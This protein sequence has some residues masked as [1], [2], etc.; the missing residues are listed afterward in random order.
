M[1]ALVGTED[2]VQLGVIP[3]VL[4]PSRYFLGVGGDVPL[5]LRGACV[6][7]VRRGVVGSAFP[8]FLIRVISC[9]FVGADGEGADGVPGVLEIL[10]P[11]LGDEGDGGAQ[12]DGEPS[13]RREFFRDAEGDAGLA[14][15][16]WQDDFAAGL[17]WWQTAASGVLVFSEDADAFRYGFP[18]HA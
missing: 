1:S 4:D 17:A 16:A 6:A 13:R 14:R 8:A 11:Y 7:H 15:A 9:G 18:L 12:D 3:A 10:S 2:H 5:H